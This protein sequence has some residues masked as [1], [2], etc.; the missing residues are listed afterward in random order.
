MKIKMRN[1]KLNLAAI[2]LAAAAWQLRSATVLIPL[3]TCG[4]APAAERNVVL[5]PLQAQGAN[6]IPVMDKMQ[7]NTDQN[8]NVWVTL[9]PGVYQ[10][11][12]R[13]AWGQVGVTEF[14]FY[15]DPSN[16]VQNAFTNLLTATNN[17][18]PP[19][20]YAY[21]AQASDARYPILPVTSNDIASINTGQIYPSVSGSNGGRASVTSSNSSVSVSVS[22]SNGSTNFDLGIPWAP[23][24]VTNTQAIVNFGTISGIMGGNI[25]ISTPT[26]T[27]SGAFNAAA[28][29]T[30]NLNATST[31]ST[32]LEGQQTNTLNA[33]SAGLNPTWNVQSLGATGNGQI[34]GEICVTNGVIL[35]SLLGR[36]TSAD[37]GDRCM[38]AGVG[39]NIWNSLG[40]SSNTWFFNGISNVINSTEIIL[41]NAPPL[42]TTNNWYIVYGSHDDTPAFQSAYSNACIY[43]GN[44]YVPHGVYLIEGQ[45]QQTN[46]NNAQI[47]VPYISNIGG[48]APTVLSYGDQA[49]TIWSGSYAILD[50]QYSPN[51]SIV[52][53]MRPSTGFVGTN[54]I[55]CTMFDTRPAVWTEGAGIS[56]TAANVAWPPASNNGPIFNFQNL[57][58]LCS[59]DPNL[60][61]LNLWASAQMTKFNNI[62][63]LAGGEDAHYVPQP[64]GTNGYGIILPGPFQGVWE[65]SQDVF[66]G[67]FYNDINGGL[68]D[69]DRV[70]LSCAINAISHNFGSSPFFVIKQLQISD[71]SSIITPG[72]HSAFCYDNIHLA[73]K[74]DTVVNAGTYNWFTNAGT[75]HF[76]NDPNHVWNSAVSELTGPDSY[77]GVPVDMIGGSN[78]VQSYDYFTGGLTN[79]VNGQ[80]G[81]KIFNNPV[82]FQAPAVDGVGLFANN[83]KFG[84]TLDLSGV[85]STLGGSALAPNIYTNAPMFLGTLI[86]GV[87][88]GG[89][90]SLFATNINGGNSDLASFV[91]GTRGNY[92]WNMQVNDTLNDDINND[93]VPDI[94][95]FP[96]KSPGSGGFQSQPTMELMTNGTV[97]ANTGFLILSNTWNLQLETNGMPIWAGK[98]TI[99][100]GVPV[101]IYNSNGIAFVTDP[102]P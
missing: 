94:A 71:C 47:V 96:A 79:G 98:V 38:V 9:M 17:T 12:V 18:Y 37:I 7:T 67:G 58:F 76:L 62:W 11:A 75:V 21:S 60:T 78:C 46:W 65:D 44:V 41:S 70:T 19:N 8:G 15:V 33:Q 2:L 68:F 56:P 23:N 43:G 74:Q 101:W 42:G 93:D 39:T 40:T 77:E 10:T 59:P 95:F 6:E 69:G 48:L 26:L 81:V 22:E 1:L 87:A 14:Y 28:I 82:W 16:A 31:N 55:S 63:V 57:T 24:V 84:G 64:Y 51:A 90:F 66:V 91:L 3:E 85:S 99:S 13:P 100:N 49:A 89:G 27:A 35:T 45:F 20:Q 92:G 36:W 86:P 32:Y 72:P 83:P 61:I 80:I 5:T 54:N 25:T 50:S 88:A 97:Q 29:N 34:C 52:V 30:A 53:E 102:I 73:W 4:I